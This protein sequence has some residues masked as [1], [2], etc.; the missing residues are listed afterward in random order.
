MSSSSPGPRRLALDLG[1]AAEQEQHDAS[2]G[3][4]QGAADQGVADLVGDDAER[5]QHAEP[6]GGGV[7]RAGRRP[8]HGVADDRAVTDRQDDGHED[9]GR[10]DEDRHAADAGER[11]QRTGAPPRAVITH[12]SMLRAGGTPGREL[13]APAGECRRPF[14]GGS[15]YRTRVSQDEDGGRPAA[16]P[17][18]SRPAPRPSAVS[19]PGPATPQVAAPEHAPDAVA[20]GGADGDAG[21]DPGAHRAGRLSRL[22]HR[23]DDE[24]DAGPFFPPE[25]A[26]VPAPARSRPGPGAAAADVPAAPAIP[27]VAGSTGA[28]QPADPDASSGSAGR[29]FRCAAG[30]RGRYEA[31]PADAPAAERPPTVGPVPRRAA[32]GRDRAARRNRE[33]GGRRRGPGCRRLGRAGVSRATRRCVHVVGPG[34]HQPVRRGDRSRGSRPRRPEEAAARP[35]VSA[36]AARA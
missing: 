1:D 36:C 31:P 3:V 34:R 5:E 6:G 12:A 28:L 19:R 10:R 18:R 32:R 29:G 14:R 16:M 20:P 25:T 8:R 33:H 21:G 26:A 27:S 30:R 15:G 9:P 7:G 13:A 24:D 35:R 4:A 11:D 23:R 22:L 2:H 17:A